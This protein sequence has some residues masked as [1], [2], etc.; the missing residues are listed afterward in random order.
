M[1]PEV[2]DVLHVSKILFGSRLNS[3]YRRFSL[4]AKLQALA[5][6][7][8]RNSTSLFQTDSGSR[9]HVSV[10]NAQSI[11]SQ[12]HNVL[13]CATHGSTMKNPHAKKLKEIME[14]GDWTLIKS[15]L[16]FIALMWR[17][18]CNPMFQVLSRPQTR[19]FKQNYNN[20]SNKY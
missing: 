8:R 11:I 10:N 12:E 2:S 17:S 13:L 20:L 14:H 16:A 5:G 1:R 15:Q 18:V 9:I 7:T 3:G 4:K 6:L 19:E